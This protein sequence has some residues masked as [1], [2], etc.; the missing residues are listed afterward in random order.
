MHEASL[1]QDNCFL[2]LTYNDENIP[3][4]GQL[5]Y[6]DFQLF[7]KRLRRHAKKRLSFYMC[8]E[9]APENER[10]HFHACIFGFDFPDRVPAQLLNDDPLYNSETL[11]RLWG[12]GFST[13]G[14]LTFSS[15]AYVARYCLKKVTGFNAKYHYARM[16]SRGPYSLTPEFSRC[17][18]RP[19]IGARW[20]EKFNSDVY[21]F[22]H[23]IVNGQETKPPRYYDKKLGLSDPDRLE[24]LQFSR[25]LRGRQAYADNTPERLMA[26]QT[27][28]QARIKHL[29]RKAS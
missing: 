25:A 11:D 19:G 3:D 5:V 13:I 1:H 16:D 29:H 12:L 10:P 9:Y 20:L 2:S 8:G 28:T 6:R 4:R 27:V 24:E 14:N 7:M 23:V 18:L 15:A 22:D 26:R 17:S 21:N